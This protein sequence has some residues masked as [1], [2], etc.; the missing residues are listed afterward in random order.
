M[1]LFIGLNDTYGTLVILPNGIFHTYKTSIM[2]VLVKPIDYS[3]FARLKRN[4]T[5][6]KYYDTRFMGSFM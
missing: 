2:R 5:A 6:H 3:R 4:C 1:L